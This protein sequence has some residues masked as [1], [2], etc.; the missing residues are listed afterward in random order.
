MFKV[1]RRVY[2]TADGRLCEEDDPQVAF[3][4]YVP[5]QE[6]PDAEARR[7]GL[8]A[9]AVK[10]KAKPA[11]KAAARPADKAVSGLT[12]NR[13]SRREQADA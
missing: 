6:V 2:R 7:V 11:D 13:A 12:I 10:A 4:A 8:A 1:T 5:G 9:F 3:L